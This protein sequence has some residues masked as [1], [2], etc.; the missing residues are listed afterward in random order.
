M[1]SLKEERKRE[2]DIIRNI[3]A[4]LAKI[5]GPEED[6]AGSR[7]SVASYSLNG[8][9]GQAQINLDGSII[10]DENENLLGSVASLSGSIGGGNA[11]LK[12][13]KKKKP[14]KVSDP[15]REI[16]KAM[17]GTSNQKDVS[18]QLGANELIG[19]R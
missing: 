2:T 6:M 13:K 16:Q 8:E 4:E 7:Y 5:L 11:G 10:E 14:G 12:G 1:E 18:E 19:I 9:E 3:N 15:K 17:K